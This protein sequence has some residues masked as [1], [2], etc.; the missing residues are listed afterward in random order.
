MV[1]YL[2]VVNYSDISLFF[3]KG[4]SLSYF[5]QFYFQQE[6]FGFKN[7]KPVMASKVLQ[8]PDLMNSEKKFNYVQL[9]LNRFSLV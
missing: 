7:L 8:G 4:F 1:K 6:I 3:I 2:S 9:K 5:P